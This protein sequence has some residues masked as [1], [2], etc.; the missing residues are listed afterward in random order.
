MKAIE[1][2][3]GQVIAVDRQSEVAIDISEQMAGKAAI[4]KAAKKIAN[5]IIPH[6]VKFLEN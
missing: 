3:T 2:V 1:L 4:E 6:I 5:R